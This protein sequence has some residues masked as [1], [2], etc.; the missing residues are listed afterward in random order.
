MPG[1]WHSSMSEGAE[2]GRDMMMVLVP[3][4]CNTVMESITFR[5]KETFRED[6]RPEMI[7]DDVPVQ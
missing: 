2:K 1:V 4:G 5:Y 3:H 7:S 6:A